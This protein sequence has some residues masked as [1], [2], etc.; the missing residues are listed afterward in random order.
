LSDLW[1]VD[2]VILKK[3]AL[4]AEDLGIGLRNAHLLENYALDAIVLVIFLEIVLLAQ[5]FAIVV[6]SLAMWPKIAKCLQKICVIDAIAP[7]TLQ[8]I[9]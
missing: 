6:I 2:R 5:E 1:K 3:S 9:V 7:D 8:E 4:I